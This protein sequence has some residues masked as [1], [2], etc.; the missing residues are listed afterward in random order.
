[1]EFL[2]LTA[3]ADTVRPQS[4]SAVS[5]AQKAGIKVVMV[6][7][8]NELTAKAIG[9]KVGILSQGDEILL[10]S[11][12]EKLTDEEL[13]QTIK[14]VSIFARCAPEHKL[15]IVQSYQ[16]LGEVVAVTGDGVNDSL[17]LKQAQIGV[18]MG[19]IGTDVAKE[20][21]D[22]IIMDDNLSTIVDAIEQGRL[23]YSNILK[24]VKFLMAGNLSEVAV[25]FV[26]GLLGFPAPLQPVQILW[27]NFVTDGLPALSLAFDSS[28]TSLM[29]NKPRD[30]KDAMLG[31]K[32]LSYILTA[33][34]SMSVV[35]TIAYIYFY[36]FYTPQ[37]AQV[38]T[39]CLVVLTQMF[40]VFFL[41]RH[42]SPFSNKYLLYSVVVVLLL[43]ATIIFVPQL[44]SV[45]K[46]EGF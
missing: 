4:I 34:I 38:I 33:G 16:R 7:G 3:I 35:T 9:E 1:M 23:I 22:I 14:Q 30:P 5:K 29:N 2:G 32:N 27:I 43:Q 13:D 26:T 31:K 25:I 39:F 45:F 42:H 10:G 46:I 21:S 15:R 12:L 24:T 37:L 18:A 20:A 19:K 36:N 41:R 40:Y 8:D 17:A 44:R 11:Q 6:T 28:S